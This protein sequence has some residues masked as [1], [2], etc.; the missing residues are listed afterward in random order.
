MTEIT[1]CP[2]CGIGHLT[3]QCDIR[4][5]VFD[6]KEYDLPSYYAVCNSCESEV[7]DADDS[8]QNKQE[9]LKIRRDIEN[10]LMARLDEAMKG[11]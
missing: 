9:M 8:S 2:V 10:R 4:R 1:Q 6:N 11:E 5:F 3:P 7:A